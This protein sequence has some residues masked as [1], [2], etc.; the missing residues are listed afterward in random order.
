MNRRRAVFTQLLVSL[1]A[2]LAPITTT[3]TKKE[4]QSQSFED[5]AHRTFLFLATSWRGGECVPRLYDLPSLAAAREHAKWQEYALGRKAVRIYL[6][7]NE[8]GFWPVGR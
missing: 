2:V 7:T 8:H 6:K 5:L 4:S 1:G 3:R